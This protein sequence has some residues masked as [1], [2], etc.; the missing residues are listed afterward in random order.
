[1]ECGANCIGNSQRQL[2]RG[3]PGSDRSLAM[4]LPIEKPKLRGA[5]TFAESATAPLY[6]VNRN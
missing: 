2:H 4:P 5:I 3:P 6:L 1:L